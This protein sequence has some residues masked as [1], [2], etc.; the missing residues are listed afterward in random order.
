MAIFVRGESLSELNGAL[1]IEAK[2][3]AAAGR[4][5][6]K[7]IALATAAGGPGAAAREIAVPGADKA[8]ALDQDEVGLPGALV[9]A[10]GNGRVALAIG[11]EAAA[12]AI[13]A[14][15]KLADSDVFD[16]AGKAIGDVKPAFFIAIPQA[17]ALAEAAGAADE[18]EWP[19]IK[20]YLQAFDVLATGGKVDGDRATT[21]IGVGLK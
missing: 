1:V 2:D 8:L 6:D 14:D 19:M 4:A 13:N 7:L 11:E 15:Q 18:A 10:I 20:Q 16:R 5:V 17:V 9:L 12:D 3:E 21:R